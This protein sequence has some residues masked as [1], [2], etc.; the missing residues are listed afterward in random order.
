MLMLCRFCGFTI[1][2]CGT[3]KDI[4]I[5]QPGYII[6]EVHFG[7]LNRTFPAPYFPGSALS[8]QN[9]LSWPLPS[10]ASQSVLGAGVRLKICFKAEPATGMAGED[11]KGTALRTTG[12]MG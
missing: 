3:E 2:L 8:V 10:W 4:A 1:V 5:N 12:G 9:P 6:Q 7:A 11:A